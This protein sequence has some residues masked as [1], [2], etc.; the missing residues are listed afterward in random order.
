MPTSRTESHVAPY[1]S[2]GHLPEPEVVR[3]LVAEAHERYKSHTE[4]ENSQVYPAL[5]RVP[6]DLF[7][8]CVVGTTGNV[9]AV[10]D[11][12]YEFTIM[13]VSK[14]SSP[15]FSL[16]SARRWGSRMCGRKLA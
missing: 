7:G 16:W 10:G 15:S 2:T 1:V 12:D 9:Y 3:K 6:S 4:G 13:S 8:V 5:A 11:S 14:P